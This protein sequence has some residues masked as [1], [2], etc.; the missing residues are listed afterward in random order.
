MDSRPELDDFQIEETADPVHSDLLDAVDLLREQ[1][2]SMESRIEEVLHQSSPRPPAPE[3]E[4][5]PL[6]DAGRV[7]REVDEL[8]RRNE[9]ASSRRIRR[10]QPPPPR[11]PAFSPAAEGTRRRP[12][13]R[14]AAESGSMR[15]ALMLMVLAELF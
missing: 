12:A 13:L 5:D 2:S 8:L 11:E 9:Q 3:P 14:V 1:I 7:K 6:P 4:P 15:K 10:P